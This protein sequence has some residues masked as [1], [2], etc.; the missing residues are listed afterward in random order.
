MYK[1][2][3]KRFLDIIFSLLFIII[4]LPLYI[5]LG[6]LV[7]VFMGRP[8]IFK[9]KRPGKNEKIFNIYKFRTMT[10]QKDESGKLLPDQL[11]TSKLGKF[12]RKTSLD[13]LPQLFNVLEG[14]MSLVGPRPL[15]T[16]YLEL[17]NEEQKHRHDIKP[18]LT[19]WAQVNGRNSITW[20]EKFKLDIYYVKNVSFLLDVKIVFMT[21]KQSIL[22]LNKYSNSEENVERFDG[23]N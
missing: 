2:F 5:I 20:S 18:G 3:L 14:K 8:I 21:F 13:E 22:M 15:R 1:K 23:K 12:L 11:R 9:Q 16:E 10:E 19:G 6:I 17:Y 4:L 7:L